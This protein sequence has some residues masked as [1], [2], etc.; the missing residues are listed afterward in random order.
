MSFKKFNCTS[1]AEEVKIPPPRSGSAKLL[2]TKDVTGLPE[3]PLC[4][5]MHTYQRGMQTEVHSN[6]PHSEILYVLEGRARFVVDGETYEADPGC[7]IYMPS[8]SKHQVINIGEGELRFLTIISP[9][10]PKRV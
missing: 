9:A 5:L 1:E 6:P 7:A 8:E 3:M 2:M 4:L 10:L